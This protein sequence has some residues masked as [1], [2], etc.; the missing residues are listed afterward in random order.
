MLCS[1]GMGTEAEVADAVPG[2]TALPALLLLHCVSSYPAPVEQANL[3]A[4]I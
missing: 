4:L 1:T 2:S 3:R